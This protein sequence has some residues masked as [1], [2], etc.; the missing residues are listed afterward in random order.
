[1]GPHLSC[2]ATSEAKGGPD[3]RG[4]GRLHR[5]RPM[6]K[7]HTAAAT[8]VLGIACSPAQAQCSRALVVPVTIT[9][10]AAT[11]IE[12]QVHGIYPDLLRTEAASVGC[13]ISFQI[14]PRARQ[15]ML[16]TTGHADL[17]L[18]ARRVTRRD[19]DGIFV[20]MIRSRPVLIS[21]A[22]RALRFHALPELLG[23][24]TLRVGI[25]RGYDYGESYQAMVRQ[26]TAQR[27]LTEATDPISLARMLVDGSIDVAVITPT[28]LTG[29]L[30]ANAKY[31]QLIQQ[32]H[33]DPV[34][35][36]PWGESG[37][38][39]TRAASLS[40]ADRQI[41]LHMVEHIARS[42]AVWRG[43]QHYYP[44]PRLGDSIGPP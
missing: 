37:A 17:L 1:M 13:A 43:F 7:I 14:V 6:M 5:F 40:D 18:P 31:R 33:M 2:D 8:L 29:A 3:I 11:V 35:E 20:P 23:R 21:L 27:R 16:F 15:E 22:S 32:L 36:L 19:D 41:V 42:G 39:V 44:D 12:G 10:Y 9:G 30:S 28:A 24:E 4:C 34:P 25:M 26:L 38:Y